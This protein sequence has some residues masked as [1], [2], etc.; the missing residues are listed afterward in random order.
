[1]DSEQ[2][3]R[4]RHEIRSKLARCETQMIPKTRRLGNFLDALGIM[5]GEFLVRP[6]R[7]TPEE[8]E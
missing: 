6:L 1:M 3:Q 7:F 8:F 4:E 2:E 5:V